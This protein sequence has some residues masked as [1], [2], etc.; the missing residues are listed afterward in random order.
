MAYLTIVVIEHDEISNGVPKIPKGT[1]GYGLGTE[2]SEG[3]RSIMERKKRY[4][5]SQDKL[6]W[7][8][9]A[10]LKL[11]MVYFSLQDI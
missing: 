5:T 10:S 6:L 9:S 2:D 1:D 4:K 3:F 8:E 7:K 11:S